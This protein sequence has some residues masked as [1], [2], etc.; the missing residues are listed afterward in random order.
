MQL[1]KKL[2]LRKMDTHSQILEKL[3]ASFHFVTVIGQGTLVEV[4]IQIEKM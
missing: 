3:N 2:I 1:D 4:Y